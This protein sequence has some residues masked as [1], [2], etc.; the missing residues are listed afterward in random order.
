MKLSERKKLC[1]SGG[2]RKTGK[3]KGQSMSPESRFAQLE[4]EVK[5]LKAQLSGLL[6]AKRVEENEKLLSERL[7]RI[8]EEFKLKEK[9]WVQNSSDAMFRVKEFQNKIDKMESK[10]IDILRIFRTIQKDIEEFEK[11]ESVTVKL[12]KD[13]RAANRHIDSLLDI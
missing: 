4:C 5:L 11:S 7:N 9:E 6:M 8:E 13:M 10:S 1:T 2:G 12:G 3:C